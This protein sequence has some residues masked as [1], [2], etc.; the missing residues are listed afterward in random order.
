MYHTR[1]SVIAPLDFRRLSALRGL[2]IDTR[3]AFPFPYSATAP[4]CLK[5]TPGGPVRWPARGVVRPASAQKYANASKRRHV[6]ARLPV[7]K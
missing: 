2:S 1:S 7:S 6:Y 3:W 4:A 5:L